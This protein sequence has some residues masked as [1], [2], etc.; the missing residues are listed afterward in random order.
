MRVSEVCPSRKS[1]SGV[2]GMPL[3][4][5][6]AGEMS[7]DHL[8]S[9]WDPHVCFCGLVSWFE[10]VLLQSLPFKTQEFLKK[11]IIIT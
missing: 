3:K 1:F 7:W 5:D 11:S 10:Q 8:E 6:I 9:T 2:E 4:Q